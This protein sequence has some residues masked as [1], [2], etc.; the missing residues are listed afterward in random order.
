MQ[1]PGGQAQT[2][3]MHRLPLSIHANRRCIQEIEM[4]LQ[5]LGGGALHNP[6]RRPPMQLDPNLVCIILLFLSCTI[7]NQDEDE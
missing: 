2:P 1:A 4:A 6:A 7:F 3:S 5:T